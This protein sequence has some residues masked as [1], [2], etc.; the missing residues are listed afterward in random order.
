V[1]AE[2]LRG[3]LSNWRDGPAK[4]EIVEL[5]VRV[6]GEDASGQVPVVERPAAGDETNAKV[7]LAA[8]TLAAYDGVACAYGPLA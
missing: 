1:R 2:A 6:Y 7:V 5:V 3:G 4:L 8:G